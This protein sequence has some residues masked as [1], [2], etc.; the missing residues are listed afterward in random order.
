[1]ATVIT[2]KKATITLQQ[3]QGG[4]QQ[5]QD[6]FEKAIN[7]CKA[8][9]FNIV[10]DFLSTKARKSKRTAIVYSIPLEYLNRFIQ[11]NYKGY[12]I[13]TILP[14]VKRS[15]QVKGEGDIVVDYDIYKL[16]NSFV[17]YLQNGTKNGADLT[18]KT[19]DN[20]MISAR[21]YF[22]YN[23]IDISPAK[24]KYKISMPP[25]YREDE[26]AIDSTDIKEILNHCSIRRLNAYLLVLASGGMRAVEALAIRECDIDFSLINF[27]DRTDRSEPAKIRIRKEYAKTRTERYIFISNEAA[28]YLHDWIEWKYRDRHAENKNL[29][30]KIRNPDDLVFSTTSNKDPN[31]IYFKVLLEFQKLLARI[32]GLES[33]KE[34]GVYK[35]RKVTFHSFRRFVK[36]TIANQTRN[37]AYSEWFLGHKKSPYY[38]NKP[39][40]LRRIYKEDCMKYL[41]FLDYPTLEA[42]G[43]SYEAKLK[44]KDIEI[45]ALKQ[46]VSS[47]KQRDSMNTDAIGSLTDKFM[48]LVSE[49]EELKKKSNPTPTSS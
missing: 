9:G 3:Q 35:R 21:S 13:Q 23:D 34:D 40:E 44:E 26:Q 36:T 33:R 12:D 4:E 45:E 47:L 46:Q 32:A 27:A 14:L 5:K 42:T 18:S 24:F 19:I 16:L 30:N 6:K 7:K 41:T 38:T 25:I 29:Q 11:Q 1:M 39:E 22:Q 10:A 37:D 31:A 15:E 20:Y 17:T 43:R 2:E 8:K 49:V 28:R 48:Q